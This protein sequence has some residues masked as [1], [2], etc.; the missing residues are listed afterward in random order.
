LF[1]LKNASWSDLG[2][3]WGHLGTSWSIQTDLGLAWGLLRTI[4]GRSWSVFV[5]EPAL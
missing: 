4:L 1:I 5:Q 3:S 2:A